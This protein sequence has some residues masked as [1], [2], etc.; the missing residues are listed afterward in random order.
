MS[1]A[2]YEVVTTLRT[3]SVLADVAQERGRQVAKGWTPE[4]DDQHTT[5]EMLELATGRL[6]MAGRPDYAGG[7][8]VSTALGHH[9]RRRLLEGIAILV[10]AVE[11]MDRRVE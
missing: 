9:D 2:A 5:R 4:H 8:P 7:L 6:H 1:T 3:A 10:A 11:A